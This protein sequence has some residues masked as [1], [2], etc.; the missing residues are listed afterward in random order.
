VGVE[1]GIRVNIRTGYFA[2]QIFTLHEARELFDEGLTELKTYE[3][4]NNKKGFFAK[5]LESQELQD[6]RNKVIHVNELNGIIMDTLKTEKVTKIVDDK[7]ENLES[8]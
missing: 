5:L 2:G 4:E 8:K 1:S 3:S 7:M 6:S